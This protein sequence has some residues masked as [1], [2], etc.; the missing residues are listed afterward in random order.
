MESLTKTRL[1]EFAGTAGDAIEFF[2]VRA[3]LE[4][5]TC[6]GAVRASN[7]MG[8]L[9]RALGPLLPVTHVADTNLR[10]ALPELD[11][12]ARR[13]VIR[14]MW[15]SLGRTA[16]EFPHLADLAAGPGWDVVNAQVLRDQA[17]RG[18]P[19]IFVSGHIGNWEMLPPMVA[20]Y[21]MKFASVY[22]P[23]ANRAV[24]DVIV[25]LRRRAM[26]EEVALFAK[27]SQGARD[28][29]THLRAGRYL[30]MLV[31]QKMNHGVEE[32]LFGH[33]A[34]TPAAAGLALKFRGPV[35]PGHVQRIAPARFRLVVENPIPLPDSGDRQAD[36]F[37]LTQT[38][39]DILERWIRDRPHRWLWLHR[40]F[41]KPLYAA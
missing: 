23:A 41:P 28:A 30:G 13:R 6:L 29:L 3:T 11:A 20:A 31:D 39:N 14:D 38:I 22:R 7:L 2:L 27:G 35:I 24:D 40:R 5:L 12:T 8:G 15:E 32:K 16:G 34:M 9:F 17:Q 26:R 36:I 1:P 19:A 21:G 25:D 4:L 33:A 37:S 10:L 18:G